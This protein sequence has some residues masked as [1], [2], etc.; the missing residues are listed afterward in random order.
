[1]TLH[2]PIRRWLFVASLTFA[3]AFVHAQSKPAPEPS[4]WHLSDSGAKVFFTRSCFAHGYMHGYEEGFHQ[5]DLDLQ[6]GRQFQAYKERESFKKI[7]GYRHGFGDHGNFQTGYRKG[8]AVGYIDAYAGR[9]FRAMQLVEQ[10][11]TDLDS[12]SFPLPDR[13][14]DEVFLQGYELGQKEGLK[15]GRAANPVLATNPNDC[16][17][18]SFANDPNYCNAYQRGY[19]LGYSDGFANQRESA[20]VFAKK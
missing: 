11:K 13:H 19:R 1:M 17:Q 18:V 8:Y 15:D 10:A 12:P 14:F 5:G 16:G 9:D 6:L 2:G 7:R 20:P 3:S 4:D